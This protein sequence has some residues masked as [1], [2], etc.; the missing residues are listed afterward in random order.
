MN[1]ICKDKEEAK[2]WNHINFVL[3][4]F[5]ANKD[6][7]RLVD[8]Y[9]LNIMMWIFLDY[10]VFVISYYWMLNGLRGYFTTSQ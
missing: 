3:E 9:V 10:F 4:M 1:E 7:I 8:S 2:A 6:G 5:N